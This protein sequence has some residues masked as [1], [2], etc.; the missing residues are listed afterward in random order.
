MYYIYAYL[1]VLV[2]VP[3][4]ALHYVIYEQ[5]LLLAA[6]TAETTLLKHT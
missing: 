3:H 1:S 2:Y 6:A 4:G 5:A